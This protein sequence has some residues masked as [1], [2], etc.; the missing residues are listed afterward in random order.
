MW[1][2][3]DPICSSAEPPVRSSNKSAALHKQGTAS[4]VWIIKFLSPRQPA[5]RQLIACLAFAYLRRETWKKFAGTGRH[6]RKRKKRI[7][8]FRK[9]NPRPRRPERK[10]IRP[11][12][13]R[14]KAK[15]VRRQSTYLVHRTKHPQSVFSFLLGD[16]SKDETRSEGKIFFMDCL[17]D[18]LL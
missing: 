1:R 9:K 16:P 11:M 12:M 15:M 2:Q 8:C 14:K 6:T 7:Y 10:A 18:L 5:T 17:P 3:V 13:V 4:D